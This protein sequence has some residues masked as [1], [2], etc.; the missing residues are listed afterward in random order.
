MKKLFILAFV[1]LSLY[2]GYSIFIKTTHFK[3]EKESFEYTQNGLSD[4]ADS[5]VAKKIILDKPS[6][7]LLAKLLKVEDKAKP[8]KFLVRPKTSLLSI[9]RMLRNNQQ[10][11]VKFILNKVRTRS[12]LAKLVGNTLSMDSSTA[13]NFFNSND[14]LAAFNTDTTLLLSLFIPNTFEMYWSTSLPKLMTKMK[15]YQTKFWDSKNRLQKAKSI[16]MSPLEVYILAS[17]VEEECNYDSDKTLIA[18]VYQNRLKKNMPLQACPT[19]KFAMQDFTLTRIYEKY[20]MNPSPY[21]TYKVKGLPPGPICTPSPTTI[22]LVLN[23]PTTSYL[24]FVAKA[25]FSGYHHFS[26]SFEEHSKFAKEYQLK[27]DE[28]QK[29]KQSNQK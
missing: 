10:A 5:L 25:D 4:L 21:N 9:V 3:G 6:F 12:E 16:G 1:L 17:I 14:S 18:S 28:Y 20:L 11:T 15:E 2:E 7:I 19:I 13:A 22:D 27:L 8:G 23:A 29:R 24:Y 26:T